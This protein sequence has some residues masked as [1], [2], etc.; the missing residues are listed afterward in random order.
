MG[1]CKAYVMNRNRPHGRRCR[2]SHPPDG[3]ERKPRS[4]GANNVMKNVAYST[5][6]WSRKMF[7]QQATMQLKLRV[8]VATDRDQFQQ[9]TCY[10]TLNYGYNI[11]H[12][13]TAI[14]SRVDYVIL[15]SLGTTQT[16][17]AATNWRSFDYQ[18][19]CS[20][21]CQG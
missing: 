11:A 2:I 6:G 4:G 3:E 21:M 20:K 9:Q 13:L 5:P 1:D 15:P 18:L 17:L 7:K 14:V 8:T 10:R 16:R 19:S 12:I